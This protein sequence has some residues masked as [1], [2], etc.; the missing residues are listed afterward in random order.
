MGRYIGITILSKL[1]CVL[2]YLLVFLP[3]CF[4]VDSVDAPELVERKKDF[5]V[6]V[7]LQTYEDYLGTADGYYTPN[8]A[9][10]APEKWKVKSAEVTYGPVKPELV[11]YEGSPPGGWVADMEIP[12]G[13]VWTCFATGEAY[14]AADYLDTRFDVTFKVKPGK[15][16]GDYRLFV[17]AWTGEFHEEISPGDKVKGF[18]LQVLK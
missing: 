9:L 12:D 6:T 4:Y 1:I 18:W 11:E 8:V 5:E 17:T 15:E 7:R 16:P 3:G 13:Y 14:A 2:I 10:A